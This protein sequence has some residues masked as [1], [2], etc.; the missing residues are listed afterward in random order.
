MRPPGGALRSQADLQLAHASTTYPSSPESLTGFTSSGSLAKVCPTCSVHYPAEFKVCPRDASTLQDA[1]DDILRDEYVG[2]TLNETYT[3]VRVIGEGG[4]GRVYEARHTRI[5]TKR[6]AIKMLHPEFARQPQVLSRFHREAEAA[7]TVQSPYVVDVFDVDRTQ[8]GRPFLVSEFLDGKEFAE[9]LAEGGRMAVGPAVRV[10][11]QICNALSAAHARG[12]V[13]RDMKP[14]NVFLTGNLDM[15][16][17]KVIDFGISKVDDNSGGTALT[18][19]GMIMGTPSYMAP[20]QARGERVDHRADIY[21]VGAI[22]Y[23][24]LTGQRPF[25]RGDPTATLTAVLTEDPPRPRSLEASIPAE[26]EMVI[27]RAMAKAPHDRYQSMDDFDL[28]LAPYDTSQPELL[29]GAAASVPG[30]GRPSMSSRA[31]LTVVGRSKTQEVTM[32]RPLIVLLSVLGLFGV[33]SG[34]ITMVTAIVRLARGGKATDNLTSFEAVLLTLG[35]AFTLIT[36]TILGVRY[37]SRSVWDNSMKSVALAERLRAPV[38]VALCG[39]GFA[40]LLVRSVEAV[41]LRR[42]AGIAWP[43]WDLLL[44]LVAVGGGVGAYYVTRD[45]RR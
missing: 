25:D 23:C 19:T 11:R 1:E 45:E 40:S 7:A 5:G 18:K 22:L 4:M 33:A 28:D 31:G 29:D 34:V 14:E 10:V 21:A 20:E 41:V 16:I 39:Y 36:P 32:A 17:A 12:V 3:I 43:V 42:A 9:F 30:T 27:Q 44:F 2:K 35:I 24:A 38:M 26:L 37:V 13:H 8:D 6:F 15:P